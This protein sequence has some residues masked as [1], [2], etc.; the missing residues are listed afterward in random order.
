MAEKN[1]LFDGAKAH[2][3]ALC[4]ALIGATMPIIDWFVLGDR[5]SAEVIGVLLA[6]STFATLFNPG[7]AFTI[8][9]R[10]HAWFLTNGTIGIF[11]NLGGILVLDLILKSE[12]HTPASPFAVTHAFLSFCAIFYSYWSSGYGSRQYIGQQYSESKWPDEL[13]QLQKILAALC[14]RPRRHDLARTIQEFIIDMDFEEVL[15]PDRWKE[16]ETA[17][18]S[19][20]EN[21][22]R[23]RLLSRLSR[24][25]QELLAQTQEAPH[26]ELVRDQ[27]EQSD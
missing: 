25:R 2:L 14:H 23:T 9:E 10:V 17:L 24:A 3:M 7:A 20:T 11:G 26:L 19:G 5:T 21:K 16:I 12:S 4:Y 22:H 6:C 18:T 8:K 15:R 13:P 27:Q 1:G